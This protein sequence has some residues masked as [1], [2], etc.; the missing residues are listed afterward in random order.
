M[1][2]QR[3]QP[4]VPRDAQRLSA[5]QRR[6]GSRAR[7]WCN[8][9]RLIAPYELVYQLA[10]ASNMAGQGPPYEVQSISAC[11]GQFAGLGLMSVIG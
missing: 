4:A 11:G 1:F 2:A 10:S 3:T 9:H 6:G 5:G 7:G 8:S